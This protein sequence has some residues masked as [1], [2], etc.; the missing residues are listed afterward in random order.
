[1]LVKKKKT[2]KLYEIC[3]GVNAEK[4]LH[5]FMP[6]EQ[7]AGQNHSMK[8]GGTKVWYGSDIWV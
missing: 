7:N 5:M 3:L 1:M 2:L 8:M 6:G 4:T